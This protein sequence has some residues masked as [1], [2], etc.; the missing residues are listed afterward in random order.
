MH[1][2]AWNVFPSSRRP[3]KENTNLVIYL[4]IRLAIQHEEEGKFNTIR[5]DQ[6]VEKRIQKIDFR[7]LKQKKK[8]SNLGGYLILR[9]E[10]IVFLR[11]W[12]PEGL[13]TG[14]KW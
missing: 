4:P 2:V 14:K 11:F 12:D 3:L 6:L 9:G 10:N 7:R 5:S 1:W 13:V 8:L